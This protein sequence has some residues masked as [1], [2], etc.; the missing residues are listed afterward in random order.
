MKIIIS[1]LLMIVATII[2]GWAI[3]ELTK[4]YYNLKALRYA[5]KYPY[6][7]KRKHGIIYNKKTNKLE[8]DQSPI[9]PF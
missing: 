8:A 3:I 1:I 9:T 2:I 7:S 5:S 4:V 6:T